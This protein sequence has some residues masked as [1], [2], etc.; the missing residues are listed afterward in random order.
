MSEETTMLYIAKLN[1]TTTD[2]ESIANSMESTVMENYYKDDIDTRH[3]LPLPVIN[4]MFADEVSVKS[5]YTFLIEK[6]LFIYTT[7][8]GNMAGVFEGAGADEYYY[9]MSGRRHG[10]NCCA[11]PERFVPCYNK[12]NTVVYH[13]HNVDVSPYA[14]DVKCG[15]VAHGTRWPLVPTEV[16]GECVLAN[17]INHIGNG[18]KIT[19]AH[20]NKI[21]PR[22]VASGENLDV[23]VTE[24][25]LESIILSKCD[26]HIIDFP[27]M[28]LFDGVRLAVTHFEIKGDLKIAHIGDYKLRIYDHDESVT[29]SYDK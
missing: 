27:I 16:D 17:L 20:L 15:V 8:R 21:L 2:F 4:L 6:G 11:L 23:D 12:E 26:K 29:I 28:K 18:V 22:L 14:I 13:S 19:A 9:F 7:C 3:P 5:G 24:I 10:I 25:N 1:I